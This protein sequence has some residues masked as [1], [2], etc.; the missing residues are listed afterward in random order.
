[1]HK[2]LRLIRGVLVMGLIWAVGG[3]L[4]GG[5]F[6]LV[7]NVVPAA[8][9]FTRLVDMWAPVLAILAFRR[10]V[11]FA[12]VLGL[13]RG[14]RRFEDF[15]LAQFAAWGALSGLVLGGIALLTGASVVFLAVTTLLS[16]IGGASS[17]AVARVAERRGLL[18]AGGRTSSA[19]LTAGDAPPLLGRRD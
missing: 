15:S 7:D 8:H 6:E 13:A 16:A 19:E 4:I 2:W 9:P 17:L 3:F 11:L 1:V 5:L 18:D 14:R 12:V 10:G